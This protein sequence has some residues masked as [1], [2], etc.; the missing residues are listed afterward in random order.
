MDTRNWHCKCRVVGAALT[1]VFTLV[2]LVGSDVLVSVVLPQ[3]LTELRD[4]AKVHLHPFRTDFAL[5][6]RPLVAV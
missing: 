1:S 3:M 5:D 2:T 4:A 6:E